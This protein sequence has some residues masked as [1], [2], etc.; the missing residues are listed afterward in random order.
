MNFVARVV[1]NPLHGAVEVFVAKL[2]LLTSL[3]DLS[4]RKEAVKK[5]TD[6]LFIENMPFECCT[7]L[8]VSILHKGWARWKNIRRVEKSLSPRY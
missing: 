5:E 2:L 7:R 3:L 1:L 4:V 8:D 6:V